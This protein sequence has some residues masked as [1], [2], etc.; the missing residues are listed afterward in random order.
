[1]EVKVCCICGSK[2]IERE[3]LCIMGDKQEYYYWCNCCNDIR[4]VIPQAE[5][6]ERKYLQIGVF[7]NG[8]YYAGETCDGMVYKSE[9]AFLNYPD[10]ICYIPEYGFD[11]G[12]NYFGNENEVDGYSYNDLLDICNGNET[13]CR[14][15][16]YCLDWIAPETWFNEYEED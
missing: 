10:E 16:F 8:T 2:D 11:E 3:K 4:A 5:F 7:E 12:N 13:L 6:S 9:N 14:E 15:M 1:M